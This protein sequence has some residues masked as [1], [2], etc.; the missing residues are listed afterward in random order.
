MKF[1]QISKG[2]TPKFDVTFGRGEFSKLNQKMP[3]VDRQNKSLN[4]SGI[5]SMQ[6]KKPDNDGKSQS[7]SHKTISKSHSASHLTKQAK[8]DNQK[9]ME[10]A[11]KV[12]A[13]TVQASAAK[14]PNQVD[15]QDSEEAKAK[16]HE[17]FEKN[18][19]SLKAQKIQNKPS[20]SFSDSETCVTDM[21]KSNQ[22]IN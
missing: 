10:R 18:Q 2:P 12:Q 21:V 3:L 15:N 22:E 16:L 19:R 4:V 9:P 14:V 6:A 17:I 5:K 13:A 8:H 11:K 7:S 1:E 20:T